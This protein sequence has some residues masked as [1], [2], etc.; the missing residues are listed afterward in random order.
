VGG[1]LETSFRI[2]LGMLPEKLD[3]MP[4][5]Y[6]NFQEKMSELM[7]TFGDNILRV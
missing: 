6:T 2:K 3:D 5:T 4:H 7:K 1:Y